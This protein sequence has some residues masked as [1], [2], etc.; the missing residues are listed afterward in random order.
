MALRDEDARRDDCFH[1]GEL[2]ELVDVL[3]YELGDVG[4]VRG[5]V[6]VEGEAA[7]RQAHRFT[8]TGR[9]VASSA[10]SRHGPIALTC[11]ALSGSRASMP[12][13]RPLMVRPHT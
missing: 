9:V 1:S 5:Q 4:S 3:F 7:L 12:G 2:E 11:R 6:A 8:T 10:R 13:E